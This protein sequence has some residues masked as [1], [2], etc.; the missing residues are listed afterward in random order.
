MHRR[1]KPTRASSSRPALLGVLLVAQLMVILDISAVNLAL[2]DMASDLGIGGADIAWT[3]TSYSLV[4]GS[5]LLLG[6]RAADLLGRRRLFL[7][8][9]TIF[10]LSSLASALAGSP[11]ALFAAR[12]GQGLGA[13]LLS[14]AALSI[15]TT[16]FQGPERTKALGAW[17]AVGG[18]G[19]AIGVLLGGALT[20]LDW[21]A[22]F[23]INLPVGLVLAVVAHKIVPADVARPSWRG[24]DLRGALVATTSLAALVYAISHAGTAGWSSVQTLGIGA[25]ALLGL[26]G[27]AALERRTAQP[28][29][30]VERLAD[31][32]VGGGFALMLAAS[33]VLFGTFLLLSVYMQDVLGT[34]PLETGLAFL[35]LA[36][37]AG[38]GAHVGSQLVSRGGVR[39]PMAG[40]FAVS[41]AGLLLL[42]GADSNGSYLTDV[43]PGMLI[44]GVGL[45]VVLVAVAVA[46]LTGARDEESGMLSGLNTTGHEIGGSL[47]VAVLA[48]IALAAT[49]GTPGP[50]AA[51][52]F[53]TG[54][55]DAF[56]AAAA[57]AIAASLVAL[58]VLPSAR[59]FLPRLRLA[60]SSM[61]IH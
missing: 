19:A 13:A 4:F 3:I 26:A 35:P 48:T 25:M 6:G 11:E 1:P 18:A 42:S 32:A 46:V 10:T 54:I 15:I 47:G 17:G 24:L 29:L 38:A 51:A 28:L 57:L 40:A 43:L 12:A 59:A 53:G 2:P 22:I 31:R 14:P 9:L 27:F 58:I 55:S 23:L 50:G 39:V 33:A 60:P 7:A 20:E 52:E 16:A 61:P 49:G 45:G 37:A 34:A 41:A 8:G 30:R 56:L 44:A 5:L 36:L 21:R